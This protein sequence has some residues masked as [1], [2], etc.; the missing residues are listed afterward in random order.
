MRD[1]RAVYWEMP[2]SEREQFLSLFIFLNAWRIYLLL[3]SRNIQPVYMSVFWSLTQYS[4]R[5]SVC[6]SVC[7]AIFCLSLY[8]SFGLFVSLLRNILS[9]ILCLSVCLSVCHARFYT[10]FCQSFGLFVGLSCNNHDY[11]AISSPSSH[12]KL[13][14]LLSFFMIQSSRESMMPISGN[15]SEMLIFVFSHF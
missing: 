4:V 6:P 7:H 14:A 9:F 5:H 2:P 12:P 1:Q 13:F 11:H 8:L 3:T 15:I 10:P